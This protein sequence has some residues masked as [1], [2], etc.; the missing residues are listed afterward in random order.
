YCSTDISRAN[1]I[2]SSSTSIIIPSISA[3]AI[4]PV[5]YNTKKNNKPK[6]YILSLPFIFLKK[7]GVYHNGILLLLLYL[8]SFFLHNHP[9]YCN[10]FKYRK[11]KNDKAY[12]R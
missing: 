8:L 11:R 1:N 2:L 10:Y 9:T 12:C 7:G 5:Q 6:R 4:H 3:C